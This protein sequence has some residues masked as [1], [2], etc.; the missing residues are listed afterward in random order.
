MVRPLRGDR[1]KWDRIYDADRRDPRERD[2]F[3]A[4]QLL[5]EHESL[6]SG[7]LALD[8][9]C[10]Y[11]GNALFAAARGYTVHA[12]DISFTALAVLQKEASRRELDVHCM[13]T[14]IDRFPLPMGHYDLV[15]IFSFFAPQLM[16]A[17]A[18][19]LKP[20][21]LVFSSTFN[22]RHTSVKPGFNPK[23]LVPQG[24]LAKFFPE[25]AILLDEPD[26]GDRANLSRVIARK[27]EGK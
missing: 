18:A 12:V 2:R 3:R 24:G 21:G 20:A 15:L 10:G 23:Y 26:A 16:P 14:D 22:H 27:A 17:V 25:F 11:G 13:L 1:T 5:T 9:A 6:L 8:L 7:G 19:S 4:D